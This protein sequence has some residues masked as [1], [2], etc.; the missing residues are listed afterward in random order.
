MNALKR[1]MEGFPKGQKINSCKELAEKTGVTLQYIY[2][3]S[4]SKKIPLQMCLKLEEA[5]GGK[6]KRHELSR[7]FLSISIQ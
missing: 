5:T 6:I 3:L 4:K 1:Y 7:E 2:M